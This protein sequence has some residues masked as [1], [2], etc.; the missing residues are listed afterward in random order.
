M[1][2]E[3]YIVSGN[4]RIL[5]Q[6]ECDQQ[7]KL[8]LKDNDEEIAVDLTIRKTLVSLKRLYIGSD[9]CTFEFQRQ[10]SLSYMS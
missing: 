1:E 6:K 8:L 4:K 5:L 2:I 3:H 9:I 10:L 7:F